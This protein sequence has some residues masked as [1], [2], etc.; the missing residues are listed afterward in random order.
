MVMLPTPLWRSDEG[1][2]EGGLGRHVSAPSFSGESP[3]VHTRTRHPSNLSA[4]PVQEIQRTIRM[5][6]IRCRCV[7]IH[8][9]ARPTEIKNEKLRE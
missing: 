4:K 1:D 2:R 8:L 9:T 5:T 7:F 3:F 6:Y